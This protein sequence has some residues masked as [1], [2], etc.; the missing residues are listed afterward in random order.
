MKLLTVMATLMSA[1]A[2]KK[3]H[4]FKKTDD[5]DSVSKNAIYYNYP[6]SYYGG[7]YNPY[8]Y[9]GGYYRPYYSPIYY[10]GKQ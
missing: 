9:Y 2:V 4:N 8:A 7:Y 10:R 5:E 3:R 1:M 6:R